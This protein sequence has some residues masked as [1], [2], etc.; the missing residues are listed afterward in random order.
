M[1]AARVSKRIIH[2]TLWLRKRFGFEPRV[3]K[4]RQRRERGFPGRFRTA[5]KFN[6]RADGPITLS[7]NVLVESSARRPR[8]KFWPLGSLPL[9]VVVMWAVNTGGEALRWLVLGGFASGMSFCLLFSL[10]ACMTAMILFEPLRGFFRRAQYLSLDYSQSDPIHIV[11]PVVTL[12]AFALILQRHRLGLFRQSSLAGLVSL[13]GAIYFIQIFNP[14]QGGISVG[15]SGALF[16]LIPLSWFYFAQVEQARVFAHCLSLDSCRRTP[17]VAVRPLSTGVRFPGVR[18]VL[19]R[20][21]RL[22]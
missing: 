18:A 12:I 9:S 5:L 15:L 6:D 16:V 11:T 10:E 19:D 2:G 20:Q 1:K 8:I 22:L 21:H 17:R 14:T 7:A 13:L 3:E 4:R